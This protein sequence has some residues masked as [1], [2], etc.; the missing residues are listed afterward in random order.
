L[1]PVK[2]ILGEAASLHTAVVP[3]IVAVGNGLIVTTALPLWTCVQAV[4]LA[5]LTLTSAYV[6]VPA[7][8]VGTDTVTLLPDI[9]LTVWL[10]PPLIVYVN[11]YGS[12]PDAPVKVIFGETPS[13]HTAVV[14]LI[15][16]VG[17]GLTVTVAVP[18]CIC[19]Q[20]VLLASLTLTSAYVNVPAAVVGTD[21]V[22]LLPVVV[23]TVWLVPL[24]ILYVKVYGA[25]PLA[26]VKVIFGDVAFLHT[27]VVPVIVAVGSGLTVTTALPLCTCVHDVLPASLT[28]TSAYVYVPAVPVGTVT[29]TLL[30]VDVV[31]VWLLPPLI[32]YVNV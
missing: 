31:M 22:I 23:V 5:S 30:P 1:A 13:R 10:L 4:L 2:V 11:V 15:V 25:V 7:V 9:V 3:L 6:N 19:V 26:P 24:L 8:P 21:T 18:P 28:L 12:V 27:A 20:A 17:S 16:A 29:V 32:V 14:P